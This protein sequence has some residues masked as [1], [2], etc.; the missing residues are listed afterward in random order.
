MEVGCYNKQQWKYVDLNLFLLHLLNQFSFFVSLM[1]KTTLVRSFGRRWSLSS[2]N[3]T[4]WFPFCQL[5]LHMWCGHGH[6]HTYIYLNYH[7][8]FQNMWSWFSSS[9]LVITTFNLWCHSKTR[10]CELVIL[11]HKHDFI[12]DLVIAVKVLFFVLK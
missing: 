1:Q 7:Q 10:I 12:W 4:L 5:L 3:N 6:V 2:V 8:L 11:A 9:Y